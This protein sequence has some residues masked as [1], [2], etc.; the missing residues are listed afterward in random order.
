ME[1]T[2]NDIFSMRLAL[3]EQIKEATWI[4]AVKL[5][6]DI[7]PKDTH[8]VAYSKHFRCKIWSGDK[9]LIKGLAKKGFTKFVTTEELFSI[10]QK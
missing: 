3:Q 9:K 7:D 10:R 5:V 1:L 2:N 6:A 4:A 8:Y